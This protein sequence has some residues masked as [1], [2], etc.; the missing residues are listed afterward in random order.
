MSSRQTADHERYLQRPAG[1]N[2]L[3]HLRVFGVPEH[4]LREEA[5]TCLANGYGGLPEAINRIRTRYQAAGDGPTIR[6]AT[7]AIRARESRYQG[8]RNLSMAEVEAEM[9][10][11][12]PNWRPIVIRSLID[13]GCAESCLARAAYEIWTGPRSQPLIDETKAAAARYSGR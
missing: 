8:S 12:D 1:Q 2:L 9:D 6:A 10:E 4:K 7:E 11:Y 13:F 3:D 5:E